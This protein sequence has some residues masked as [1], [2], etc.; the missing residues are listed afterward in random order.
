MGRRSDGPFKFGEAWH[1]Q[2]IP[3]GSRREA[4]NQYRDQSST[5]AAPAACNAEP[6]GRA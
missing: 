3:A 6:E 2:F 1:G 5:R 4:K